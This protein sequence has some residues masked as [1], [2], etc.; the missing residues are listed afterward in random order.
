MPLKWWRIGASLTINEIV[1]HLENYMVVHDK[2][3][4]ALRAIAN[5]THLFANNQVSLY[6]CVM[7]NMCVLCLSFLFFLTFLKG[8]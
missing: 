4:E 3:E 8:S 7:C 2:E 5:Q 6:V 1:R